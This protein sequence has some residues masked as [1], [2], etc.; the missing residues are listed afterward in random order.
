MKKHIQN[1]GFVAIILCGCP[2]LL[3]AHKEEEKMYHNIP[4]T[5]LTQEQLAR[6]HGHMGPLVVLGAKMGEHAVT[7]HDMP[8]YFGVRVEVECPEG[9][10]STCLA[11]GLQC[12]TGA[13]MGKGNIS[14]EPAQEFKVVI[15]DTEEGKS[16]LYRFKDSTKQLLKKWVDE[17]VDVEERGRLAFEMK[18]EDL[19]EVEVKE[20][21]PR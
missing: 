2:S 15:T 1:V 11:D 19:F 12:S 21:A 17:D 16:V 9:P 18:A 8:R 13:T 14:H 6:F 5:P 20:P 3:M 7:K 10:P 4:F